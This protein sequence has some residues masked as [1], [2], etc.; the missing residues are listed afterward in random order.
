MAGDA[1]LLRQ[2]LLYRTYDG[3]AMSLAVQ[4]ASMAAWSDEAH[5]A[6]NRRRYREKFE[7]VVPMLESAVRAPRP[8]A[9]FYLWALVPGGDDEMFARDLFAATHVA[10]LPGRYLARDAHGG[11]PGR[12]YVRMVLV[13]ELADCIEA[14]RRIVAFCG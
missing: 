1:K 3:S 7:A 11:N 9:G 8:E 14:A 4:H 2:F 6:D 10:V 12:G 5:V 13:A